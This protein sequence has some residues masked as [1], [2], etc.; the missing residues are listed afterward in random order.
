MLVWDL[1]RGGED[2]RCL[3]GNWVERLI[4]DWFWM[5]MEV[6]VNLD[7]SLRTY[8]F[9]GCDCVRGWDVREISI[10]MAQ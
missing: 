5:M 2:M 4:V 6:E 3:G 10:G 7:W 1:A 8:H 9:G